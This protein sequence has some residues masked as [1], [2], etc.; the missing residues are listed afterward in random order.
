MTAD[1]D[2][3]APANFKHYADRKVLARYYE[4]AE[5]RAVVAGGMHG[6][7]AYLAVLAIS[8]AQ[9]DGLLERGGIDSETAERL[10]AQVDAGD[11]TAV[12]DKLS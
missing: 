6:R 4:V 7:Q 9:L 3:A 5:R 1:S 10:Y 2:I 8:Q 12:L 11:A